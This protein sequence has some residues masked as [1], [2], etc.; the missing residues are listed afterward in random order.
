MITI[1]LI[2]VCLLCGVVSVTDKEFNIDIEN[3]S[4]KT[5]SLIIVNL[6][7]CLTRILP[8]F[9]LCTYP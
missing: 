4:K 2:F 6:F 3:S 1:A 9:G 5:G 7:I 8:L